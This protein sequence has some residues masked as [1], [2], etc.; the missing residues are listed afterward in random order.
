MSR[1]S[2][3]FHYPPKVTFPELQSS[4]YAEIYASKLFDL[5]QKHFT[6]AY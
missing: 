2:A 4:A 1:A 5:L 3:G 6:R